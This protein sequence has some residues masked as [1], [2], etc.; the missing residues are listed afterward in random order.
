MTR[1]IGYQPKRRNLFNR[2]RK[3]IILLAAEGKNRTETQ[4]F[5][6]VPCPNHVI[7]FAPGNYTDP[8]NMVHAL[9]REYEELEL[10]PQLGDAAFCLVDSVTF[11]NK[12]RPVRENGPS[13]YYDDK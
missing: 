6:K 7:R 9:K 10:D 13:V 5:K 4:Y 12:R 2:R 3:S 8:V 11:K 1:K